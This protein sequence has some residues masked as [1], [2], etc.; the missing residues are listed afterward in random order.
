VT[1]ILLY[2]DAQVLVMPSFTNDPHFSKIAQDPSFKGWTVSVLPLGG[3]LGALINGY[4]LGK[5]GRRWAIFA[6]SAVCL[7]GDILTTIAM[8]PSYLFAGRFFIGMA[9]GMMSTAVPTFKSEVRS[10]WGYSG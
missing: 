4:V 2:T 8:A 6:A 1:D 5:V 9:V 10:H 3:W 7:L